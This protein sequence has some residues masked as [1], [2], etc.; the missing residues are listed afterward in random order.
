MDISKEDSDFLNEWAS[1]SSNNLTCPLCN[2]STEIHEFRFDPQW[3]FSDLGFTFWN[4][5]QLKDE[6]IALF[7]QKLGCEIDIVYGHL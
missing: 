4:W 6:F 2:V 5:T 3:G 1:A 7:K